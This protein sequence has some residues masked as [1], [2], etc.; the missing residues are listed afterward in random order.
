MHGAAVKVSN[1]FSKNTQMTNFMKL[2][3]VEEELLHAADRQTSGS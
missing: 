1:R 3:L 2:R